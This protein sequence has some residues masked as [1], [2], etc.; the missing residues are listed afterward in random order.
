MTCVCFTWLYMTT[1]PWCR[2]KVMVYII[3]F[4]YSR[5]KYW[6]HNVW[7]IIYDHRS[8]CFWLTEIK[9]VT[10]MFDRWSM[11]IVLYFVFYRDKHRVFNVQHTI[12]DLRSSSVS[13]PDKNTKSM[14]DMS[15]MIIVLHVFVLQD[16]NRV[17]NVRQKINDHRSSICALQ[18]WIP[19][20]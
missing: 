15:S 3:M 8:S 16:K 12:Y 7:H 17:L 10:R 20:S 9:T 2:E 6:V 18:I 13:L 11:I 19:C 4:V 5:Y 14:F 1:P